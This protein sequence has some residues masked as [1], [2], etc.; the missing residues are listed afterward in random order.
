MSTQAEKRKER[1]SA[2]AEQYYIPVREEQNHYDSA[3]EEDFAEYLHGHVHIDRWVAVTYHDGEASHFHVKTFPTREQAEEYTIEHVTDDI[4]TEVP[5][6]VVDLD[7]AIGPA[8]KVYELKKLIPIFE[9][10]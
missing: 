3:S 8:G 2:L 10:S 4:F 5:I 9:G 7:D 1:L 6:A